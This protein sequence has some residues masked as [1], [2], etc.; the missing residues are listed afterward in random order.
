VAAKTSAKCSECRN[1]PYESEQG[2]Q[3]AGNGKNRVIPQ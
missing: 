2:H 3:P 1:K